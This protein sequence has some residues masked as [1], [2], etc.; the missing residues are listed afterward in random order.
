[1]PLVSLVLPPWRRAARSLLA[2]SIVALGAC[3]DSGD[4]VVG[5]APDARG[6]GAAGALTVVYEC[7]VDVSSGTQSCKTP[8]A[9]GAGQK[10]LIVGKPY[11]AFVTTGSGSSRLDPS[12]EDTTFMSVALTNQIGQPI[13]TTD[14]TTAAA[15]GSRIFFH[16]GPVVSSVKTGT[17][18]TETARVDNASG[19]GNF[20]DPS[21]TY[22]KNGVPYYQYDGV[23]A[24]NATS[25]TKPWRFVY[26]A[27]TK[28]FTYSV[29]VSVPVRYE[30][31]WVEIAAGTVTGANHEMSARVYNMVGAMVDESVVWTSSN[32]AVVSIDSATGLMTDVGPGSATITATSAVNPLRKGTMEVTVPPVELPQGTRMVY[33]CQGGTTGSGWMTCSP[34]ELSGGMNL[35]L[36]DSNLSVSGNVMRFDLTVQNLMPEGVGTPDGVMVDTAGIR[37]F[38]ASASAGFAVAHNGDGD[39]ALYSGGAARPYFTYPQKLA[40]DEVS[41]ARTLELTFTPGTTTFNFQLYVVAE[42][43]PLLVINEV[44][45][46]P[47]G[48]TAADT[49]LEWF[50]VYNAGQLSVQME[51]MLIADSAGSGRRPYHRIASSVVVPAGGYVVMGMSSNTTLNG[52]VPV[53]YA[54]G[55]G[56]LVFNSVDA[57]KISR[58]YAAGD[59]LTLDRTQ[60]A[61]IGISSQSGVA[62]EL[63]NPW[64][65]NSNMDGSNWGDASVTSVYGTGGRGT[66]KAQNSA[67]TP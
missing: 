41:A 42:V 39:K 5:T 38:I 30:F 37:V 44:M 3:A 26:S 34:S 64:L 51:G 29:M 47:A 20:T 32:P 48:L 15:S 52:G 63:K 27:N 58:L 16:T 35:W 9:A 13:G 1:M 10:D 43:Q 60:F 62:R 31:G 11:V 55:S 67:Y 24:P 40:K 7:T 65:D 19:V 66:P 36:T 6:A 18:T 53:D 22:V 57:V 59:T 14:G 49:D 12:N 4:S 21:G 50:E 61:N 23:I 25:A 8:R 46:N 45:V 17:K 28:V 2:I 33:D 56:A 54:Y